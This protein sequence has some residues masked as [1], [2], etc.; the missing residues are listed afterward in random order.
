MNDVGVDHTRYLQHETLMRVAKSFPGPHT[1][2]WT[3]L[4][5][6]VCRADEVIGTDKEA[7]AKRV[8]EI[9]GGAAILQVHCI[10]FSFTAWSYKSSQL[11]QGFKPML[12]ACFRSTMSHW[13]DLMQNDILQDW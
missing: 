13:V 9:T 5:V 12:C 6:P 7:V 1:R 11:L 3:T 4:V 2:T 10:S 8:A